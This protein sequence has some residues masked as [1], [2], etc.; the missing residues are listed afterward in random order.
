MWKS[1]LNPDNK[2]LNIASI[3]FVSILLFS[4]GFVL[5]IGRVIKFNNMDTVFKYTRLRISH[6]PT[7]GE[8][9]LKNI[10]PIRKNRKS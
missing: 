9:D 1:Y 2:S 4:V 6:D 3:V 5:I 10:R 8:G 7:I